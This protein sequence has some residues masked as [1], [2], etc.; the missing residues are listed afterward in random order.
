MLIRLLVIGLGGFVGA[1]LR[2][3]LSG[4]LQTASKSVSFP[5]GTLGVNIIGCF[6]IGLF[7]YL[8]ETRALFSPET[9]LFVAI[10]LLGSLTTFS[11]F[12]HETFALMRD[13]A[14]MLAALNVGAQVFIGLT[15]VW[16]GRTLAQ[17]LWG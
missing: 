7:S 3:G 11:T 10:G 15:M 13:S 2:Y 8:V 14:F 12:G 1:L 16:C 17:G 5:F 4:V 6:F 9:R